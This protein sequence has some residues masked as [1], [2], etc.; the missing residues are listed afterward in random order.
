MT[1]CKSAPEQGK[2]RFRS[3]VKAVRF[4]LPVA[5]RWLLSHVFF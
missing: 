4:F 2:Q 1:S 3:V 5:V